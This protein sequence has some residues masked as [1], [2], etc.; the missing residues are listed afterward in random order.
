MLAGRPVRRSEPIQKISQKTLNVAALSD[1][2]CEG[3]TV[4]LA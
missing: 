1:F 3:A 2:L 4:V